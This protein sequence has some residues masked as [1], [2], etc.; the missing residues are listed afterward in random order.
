MTK[1]IG[2]TGG[3]GSGK[4]TVAKLFMSEGIPVYI[5]DDQ[6]KKIMEFPET[7]RKVASVFGEE[8]LKNDRINTKALSSV[9]FNNPDKLKALNAIVHPLVRQHF[10]QWV[11]ENKSFP[12]VI[13]EAAILF[14]SGSYKFCNKI[15]T[16]TASE[17]TRIRRVIER[18]HVTE[19]EVLDRIKNQWPDSEK[20]AKSD[21]VINNENLE[22]TKIQFQEILKKLKNLH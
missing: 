14:E 12:F 8:V 11:A 15:I 1:V 2:L 17:Q 5:A 20:I 9:V 13:K 7:V 4:T 6:A 16:V 10:D 18:D 19:Q 22:E 21:Y 3:I